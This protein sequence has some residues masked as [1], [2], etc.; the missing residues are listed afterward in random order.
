M[1]QYNQE[2]IVVMMLSDEEDYGDPHPM[3]MDQSELDHTERELIKRFGRESTPVDSKLELT[4][5]DSVGVSDDSNE[6]EVE[7]VEEYDGDM[8]TFNITQ[9]R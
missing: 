3:D 4:G 8:K 5:V 6:V 2:K 9:S 7:E 1:S